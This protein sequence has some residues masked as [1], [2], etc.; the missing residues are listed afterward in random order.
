MF[1]RTDHPTEGGT[2]IVRPPVR[3]SNA[4]CPLRRPAPRLGEHSR[5]ILREAGLDEQE[6]EDLLAR[7]IA[8]EAAQS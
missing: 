1:P 2:R 3:F 8:T 5:E 4:D 7:R 6:I